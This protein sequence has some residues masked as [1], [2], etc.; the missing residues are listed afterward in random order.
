MLTV[1]QRWGVFIRHRSGFT[2][3]SVQNRDWEV[4]GCVCSHMCMCVCS[5]MCM[6]VCTHTHTLAKISFNSIQSNTPPHT[7]SWA[8]FHHF[9]FSPFLFGD[10]MHWTISTS[11]LISSDFLLLI[12][13]FQKLCP[14]T[15]RTSTKT[16]L[17]HIPP[18]IHR[19]PFL[20]LP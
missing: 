9:S 7:F 6:Y 10:Q 5:H 14:S 17:P 11:D 19:S 12:I 3:P 15:P 2:D 1:A 20:S 16:P 4:W 13:S 8:C 18:C